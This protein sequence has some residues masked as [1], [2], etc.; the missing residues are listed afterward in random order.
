MVWRGGAWC[1]GVGR[2]GPCAERPRSP[3]VVTE[4]WRTFRESAAEGF[5]VGI[6]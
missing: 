5:E 6:D 4:M 1:G 2:G 3:E